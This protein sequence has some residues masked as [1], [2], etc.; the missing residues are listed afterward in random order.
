MPIS[1][2]DSEKT[3]K[4]WL[5]Y[6]TAGFAFLAAIGSISSVVVSSWQW[7]AMR[8][9]LT[10]MKENNNVIRASQE[11]FVNFKRIDIKSDGK[12][13]D[14]VRPLLENTGGGAAIQVRY[15]TECVPHANNVEKVQIPRFNFSP[16]I[17]IGAKAIWPG[18]SCSNTATHEPFY[19]FAAVQYN[20]MC[21]NCH[22]TI[23]YGYVGWKKDGNYWTSTC[24]PSCADAS[25]EYKCN[26]GIFDPLA[27]RTK[28]S[29]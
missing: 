10:V 9:Q 7:G 14:E 23:Q 21:G 27:D 12:T 1:K 20:D 22:I 13:P 6:A 3:Q 16:S 15:G 19:F 11:A 29:Q 17:I 5:E 4:H 2:A 25:C 18:K 8:A 24:A 26:E 28:N